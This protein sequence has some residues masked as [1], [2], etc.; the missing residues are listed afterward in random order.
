MTTIFYVFCQDKF[1]LFRQ[2]PGLYKALPEARGATREGHGGRC[3]LAGLTSSLQLAGGLSGDK[4]QPLLQGTT[5][6][7]GKGA[8]PS[9]CTYIIRA[10]R[11]QRQLC[12]LLAAFWQ[13]TSTIE[14][15]RA[16]PLELQST[17]SDELLAQ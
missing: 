13:R 14:V 10:F 1:Q 4:I 8:G 3:R 17:L 6:F 15:N 2:R 7:Q 11:L 12:P 9:R 16:I 5:R